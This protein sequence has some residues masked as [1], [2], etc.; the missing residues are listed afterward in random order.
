MRGKP[1]SNSNLADETSW[2]VHPPQIPLSFLGLAK[3]RQRR[4]R[5]K[6]SKRGSARQWLQRYSRAAQRWCSK[7]AEQGQVWGI[8][9]VKRLGEGK[10]RRSCKQK[11]DEGTEEDYKD[12]FFFWNG[13]KF[14][15]K[16]VDC[17]RVR[18]GSLVE[19]RRQRWLRRYV[20]ENE[21]WESGK[22]IDEL[23]SIEWDDIPQ[24]LS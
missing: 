12:F 5:G 11:M 22:R 14:K 8:R 17:H 19:G 18:Q 1:S 23:R 15:S 6:Q 24:A 16:C 2:N 7:S 13:W 21:W 4:K 10:V 3:R 9:G 20:E